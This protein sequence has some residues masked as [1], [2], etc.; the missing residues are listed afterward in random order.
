MTFDDSYYT[1][2][3]SE[4]LRTTKKALLVR[5]VDGDGVLHEVWIPRSQ[6]RD[7]EELRAEDFDVEV[8]E[9]WVAE[10]ELDR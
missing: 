5:Y 8:A 3:G 9:W 4:V 10:N 2:E 1:L 6:C 7:G